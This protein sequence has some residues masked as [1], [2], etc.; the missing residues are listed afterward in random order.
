MADGDELSESER[1]FC[2]L[3]LVPRERLE[4]SSLAAMDFES[5]VSTIPPSRLDIEDKCRIRKKNQF[6]KETSQKIVQKIPQ[7]SGGFFLHRSLYFVE[8]SY[9]SH[10]EKKCSHLSLFNII[11]IS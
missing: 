3:F 4:L 9:R 1:L 6:A 2:A 5:I 10:S 11:T 7:N 8:V